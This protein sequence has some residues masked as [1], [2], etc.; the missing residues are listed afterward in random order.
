MSITPLFGAG[1]S[2]TATSA[3]ALSQA[4]DKPANTAD[5]D[6]LV[7]FAY[8][9][10]TAT[11]ST[12]PAGWTKVAGNPG[13]GGGVFYKAI[14]SAAAETATSYTWTWNGAGRTFAT[15]FRVRGAQ[16]GSPVD[17]SAVGTSGTSGT[18]TAPSVTT[19]A[20]DDMLMTFGFWNA[21]TITTST[22]TVPAPLV[23]ALQICTPLTGNTSGGD[24]A[25]QQLTTAG[26]TGARTFT[27]SPAAT[28]QTTIT[29]AFHSAPAFTD[30]AALTGTG[31]LTA[32]GT[33]GAGGSYTGSAPLTGAGT[34]TTTGTQVTATGAASLAGT[35]TLW[36]HTPGPMDTILRN[37][38]IWVAHR[39]GSVSWP[40]EETLQAYTYADRWAAPAVM[41]FEC[42]VFQSSDGVW[43]ASHDPNTGRVFNADYDI[44]TTPW[45]TLQTLTSIVGGYPIAR[46]DELLDA[47]PDR[48]WFVDNKAFTAFTT[49]LSL[50][51]GRG[52]PGRFVVKSYGGGGATQVAQAKA[53]GY[54]TWGYF[55]ET[56]TPTLAANQGRWDLLGED[57]GAT[58]GTWTQIKSYGKPVLAHILPNAAAKATA[59]QYS[60]QGFMVSGVEAI[61]PQT[62]VPAVLAGAG[63]LTATAQP[64][65]AAAAALSG[66]GALTAS[67]S[68]RF[69]APA[70]TAGTGT[71]AAS[72]SPRS[73]ALAATASTGTLTAAGLAG[74][75]KNIT[76]TGSIARRR[77]HGST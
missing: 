46:L 59:D 53:A 32:S 40:Y 33:V 35:G 2:T 74:S 61:I 18:N 52:G 77:W 11:S 37:T 1:N 23:D 60:P 45:A 66:T 56:D 73:T 54:Q 27:T 12:D 65:T 14:P 47:F 25:Y 19:T 42:S 22:F 17:V 9:Q 20:A 39:G 13:R 5:G 28:N 41:A 58:S 72:A 15:I 43:V 36:A 71:L 34:L 4:V 63:S 70:T 8:T 31:T 16:L 62:P 57:Y 3:S 29:V 10:F 55:Y 44:R 7:A 50:L 6:L 64:A 75:R 21:S 69:T 30:T 68:P 49:F 24:I 67:A 26:A 38:P 48:A 51:D 76:V